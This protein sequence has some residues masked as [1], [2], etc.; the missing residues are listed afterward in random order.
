MK[1]KIII[2]AQLSLGALLISAATTAGL[3]DSKP[4]SVA[5]KA[6]AELMRLTAIRPNNYFEQAVVAASTRQAS[7][8]DKNLKLWAEVAD[9]LNIADQHVHWTISQYGKKIV[10]LRGNAQTLQLPA[11]E[12][13]ATLKIGSYS[14]EQP[15]TLQ[16]GQQVSPYFKVEL[17][18]LKLRSN[19]SVSWTITDSNRQTYQLD[20]QRRVNKLLPAGRYTVS[21]SRQGYSVQKSVHI[22][23]GQVLE[24]NIDMPLGKVRLL[25]S[26]DKQ[27][28]FKPVSWAIYRL[29]DRQRY[30]VGQYELHSQSIDLPPGQ[31]EA[32]AKHGDI[33]GKRQF[34][35]RQNSDNKVVL[36]L[37]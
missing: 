35:V 21:I 17:S 28:L 15:L 22:K 33:G 25:A 37:D 29:V 26:K 6:R 7:Y 24:A 10:Q 11:G 5:N 1:T 3:N 20:S 14:R 12:Y 19:H 9:A 8:A 4:V 31:Y 32:V 30:P 36:A 13:T 2:L 16:V 23:A 27:P 34:W 18:S